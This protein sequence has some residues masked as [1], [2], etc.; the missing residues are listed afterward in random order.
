M[1][2]ETTIKNNI[3]ARTVKILRS[4]SF[5]FLISFSS[6]GQSKGQWQSEK[7]LWQDNKDPSIKIYYKIGYVTVTD[8]WYGKNHGCVGTQCAAVV[9]RTEGPKVPIY[10][11]VNFLYNGFDFSDK[12]FKNKTFWTNFWLEDS[13][14]YPQNSRYSGLSGLVD[15][16]MM[17]M[18]DGSYTIEFKEIK[19][20]RKDSDN[21]T[22]EREHAGNTENSD[23]N[24]S[25]D[26][27]G[28]RKSKKNE[29]PDTDETQDAEILRQRNEWLA[30]QNAEQK[31]KN[32]KEI[33]EYQDVKK[34]QDEGSSSF[35]NSMSSMGDLF[36]KMGKFKT[37]APFGIGIEAGLATSGVPMIVNTPQQKSTP[38]NILSFEIPIR[39]PI[40]ILE[41][42]PVSLNLFPQFQFNNSYLLSHYAFGINY[43][44]LARLK[45]GHKKDARFR[46]F[47]D[48]AM[49]TRKLDY[50]KRDSTVTTG[51]NLKEY[52][53][54]NYVLTRLGGGLI[55]RLSKKR[56][57]GDGDETLLLLG[58]YS[59][60]ASFV[61]K[62][63]KSSA[64]YFMRLELRPTLNLEFSYS[65][66]YPVA[67]KIENI[68]S[69]EQKNVGYFQ[70]MVSLG[71]ISSSGK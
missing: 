34:A 54:F 61:P 56:P 44:G 71:F 37:Y 62:D 15:Y 30:K 42:K 9:F 68:S 31:E 51:N 38:K 59:D 58:V 13:K 50:E 52:G 40:Y 1:E 67:G 39:V 2:N 32:T 5:L 21:K 33:Q 18:S 28:K 20:Q 45:V 55:I 63:F 27:D 57:P 46:L 16:Q 24:S 35:V 69:M 3:F 25:Q 6:F 65:P 22:K 53:K 14:E 70:F 47:F 36:S 4:I 17:C 26:L 60:R 64:V 7:L 10:M 8:N 66:I 12:T 48:Y 43:G 29:V 19:D 23:E 41:N 11:S 49:Y